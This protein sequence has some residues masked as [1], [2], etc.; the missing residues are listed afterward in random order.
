MDHP[1]HEGWRGDHATA[2]VKGGRRMRGVGGRGRGERGTPWTII[3]IIHAG[4]LQM[5]SFDGGL[6]TWGGRSVNEVDAGNGW[7]LSR[8]VT[9]GGR[10]RRVREARREGR[11]S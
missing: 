9:G 8:P 2:D 5:L 4:V 3:I 10:E 1:V 11:D 6:A 7:R